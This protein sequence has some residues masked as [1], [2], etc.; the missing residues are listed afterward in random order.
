MPIDIEALTD[1]ATAPEWARCRGI[2]SSGLR[3]GLTPW[4]RS[5]PDCGDTDLHPGVA[6][7]VALAREQSVELHHLRSRFRD[8]EMD[9]SL[10][11][12]DRD[13]LTAEVAAWRLLFVGRAPLDMVDGEQRHTPP[14]CG[15]WLREEEGRR[16]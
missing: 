1:P 16:R 11:R 15:R 3:L 7:L 12:Q 8:A 10:M 4:G 5:C 14:T 9:A 6:E 13:E 2:C